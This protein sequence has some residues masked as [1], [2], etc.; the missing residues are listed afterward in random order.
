MKPLGRKYFKDNT[1][2]KHFV[3]I[4]GKRKTWWEGIIS[5]NKTAEK[6]Q[7]KRAIEAEIP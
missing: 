7:A 2:A 6:N 4:E 1:G 3:R 5:P